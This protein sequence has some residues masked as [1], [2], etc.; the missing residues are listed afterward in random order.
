MRASE[1][2]PMGLDLFVGVVRKDGFE[3]QGRRLTLRG[4]D[5]G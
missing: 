1:G 4:E 2:N 5:P 3:W